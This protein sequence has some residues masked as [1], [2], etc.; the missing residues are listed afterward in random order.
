MSRIRFFFF[1]SSFNV[2]E[3]YR[4]WEFYSPIASWDVF[5]KTL[6]P[7]SLGILFIYLFYRLDIFT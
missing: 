1:P 7:E 6:A 3:E 5:N 4:A 2:P